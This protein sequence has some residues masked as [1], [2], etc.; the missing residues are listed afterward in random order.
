M[1]T[2]TSFQM[3]SYPKVESKKYSLYL[4]KLKNKDYFNYI[5]TN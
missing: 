2:N 5:E 4:K 1:L 3:R